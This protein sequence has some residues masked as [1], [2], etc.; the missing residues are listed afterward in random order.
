M[1]SVLHDWPDDRCREILINLKSA[2]TKGYSKILINENVIPD[3][4]AHF[5]ATGLDMFMM[6]FSSTERTDKMWYEL[7]ASV[8]LKVVKIWTYEQGTESLIEAELA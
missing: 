1:H 4:G 3:K 5:A 7:L 8:G 6:S 2:M